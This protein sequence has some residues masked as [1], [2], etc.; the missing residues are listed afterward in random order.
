MYKCVISLYIDK[1][2]HLGS[3]LKMFY[4]YLE[5]D[6]WTDALRTKFSPV[7]STVVESVACPSTYSNSTDYI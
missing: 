5:L 4:S 2:K 3:Y 1:A 6:N 7:F